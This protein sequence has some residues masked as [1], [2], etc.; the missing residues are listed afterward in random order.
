MKGGV[1]EKPECGLLRLRRTRGVTWVVSWGRD[2]GQAR[3]GHICDGVWLRLALQVVGELGGG[4]DLLLATRCLQ[5][6][7]VL[8]QKRGSMKPGEA[9]DPPEQQLCNHRLTQ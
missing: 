2:A 4:P 7:P 8:G 5:T 9:G 6:V 3:Y 1:E